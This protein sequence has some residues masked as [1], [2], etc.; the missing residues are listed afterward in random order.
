[1]DARSPRAPRFFALRLKAICEIS[2][3]A[4][5]ARDG[6]IAI[7]ASLKAWGQP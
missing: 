7:Y 5:K 2:P 6:G 3:E 4:G 1:V